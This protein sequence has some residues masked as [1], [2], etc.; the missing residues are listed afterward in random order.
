MLM[1]MSVYSKAPGTLEQQ[2]WQSDAARLHFNFTVHP[3]TKGKK[4]VL[5]CFEYVIQFLCDFVQLSNIL[6]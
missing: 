2:I 5:L 3:K 1:N 4:R 6:H